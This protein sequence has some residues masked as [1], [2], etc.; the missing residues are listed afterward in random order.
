[1]RF[2]RT[3]IEIAR[4]T[5]YDCTA[6]A[7][8]ALHRSRNPRTLGFNPEADP[9]RLAVQTDVQRTWR[10]YGWVPPSTQ[11]EYQQK[12]TSF[13]LSTIAGLISN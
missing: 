6:F 3:G 9:Y 7:P 12:W 11:M 4:T 10:K 1:M 5:A 2:D 13:K 8:T